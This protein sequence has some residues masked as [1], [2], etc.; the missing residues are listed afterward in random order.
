MTS[1]WTDELSERLT[2]LWDGSGSASQIGEELGLSK[3]AVVGK[4][5]RMNLPP[6]PSPIK[7]GPKQSSPI[8]RPALD[9]QT[10]WRVSQAQANADQRI[11]RERGLPLLPWAITRAFLSVVG[12]KFSRCQFIA[13]QPSVDEACKCGRPTD[14]G[15][16]CAEHHRRCTVKVQPRVAA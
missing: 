6:R 3:N 8:R 10:R 15:P 13:G 9:T 1:P 12:M 7:P 4:V 14:G 16:W 2:K 11:R 5:R